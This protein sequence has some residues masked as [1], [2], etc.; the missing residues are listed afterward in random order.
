MIARTTRYSVPARPLQLLTVATAATLAT[1]ATDG[2]SMDEAMVG[3]AAAVHQPL[4]SMH[5]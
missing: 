3:G 4:L 1:Y 5:A 2:T